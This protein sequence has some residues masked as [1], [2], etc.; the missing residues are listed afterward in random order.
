M[1]LE[2]TSVGTGKTIPVGVDFRSL[3]THAD[4]RGN[5][6]EIFRKEWHDAP[7]PIQWSLSAS[8]PNV[9]RGVHVHA[10]HWDYLCVV[11]GEMIVGLHDL[12]PGAATQGQSAMLRLVSDRLTIVTIPP[13]VAHGFYSPGHSTHM[14]GA[15][16]YY[17]PVDHR[18]CRWDCPELKFDWPCTAPE[19][20]AADRA[21]PGYGELT[22]ALLHSLSEEGGVS[23]D[24]R[25]GSIED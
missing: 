11:A 18:R 12:R 23:V 24:P 20:S 16:R 17:D 6:T 4:A 15:S 14:I 3:Q 22:G 19:L 21:A 8:R 1:S 10:R 9:L 25:G 7:A 5:F 2:R 13:G